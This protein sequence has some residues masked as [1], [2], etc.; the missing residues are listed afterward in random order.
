MKFTNIF[1]PERWSLSKSAP[2][3]E[4]ITASDLDLHARLS[5]PDDLSLLPGFISSARET[6]ETMTHRALINQ[7]YV[8][9]ISELPTGSECLI[10]LPGGKIQSVTTIEYV[11]ADGAT[12]TWGASN[13]E[14][15]TTSEPGRIGLAYNASWPSYRLWGLP[16]TITYVAGYG[17]A[18][19]AV[20]A[21]LRTAV[22]MV[23]TELYE[24]RNETVIGATVASIPW[25]ASVLASPYRA[26]LVV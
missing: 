26:Y 24:M 21:A 14:V 9:K 13:Y 19:A 23:A 7:T 17:A 4:P 20:P 11:D 10:D 1:R 2:A 15:D 5:L 22:S 6:V 12:Q 25:R 8:Y 18:A 3:V 16:I